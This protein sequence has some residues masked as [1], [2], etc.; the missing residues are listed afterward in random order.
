MIALHQNVTNCQNTLTVLTFRWRIFPQ[1]IRIG[2]I[3]MTDAGTTQDNFILLALPVGGL[4][5][6]QDRLDR[7]KL[8]RD[9][10]IPVTFP[11]GKNM[12]VNM[13][14]K[15][16][17]GYTNFDTRQIQG[18]LGTES[19]FSLPLMPIG[20]GTQHKNIMSLLIK[21][22]KHIFVSPS[23][24]R[25]VPGSYTVKPGDTKVSL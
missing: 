4:P 25:D 19:A 12:L 5:I 17:V 23:Q 22:K 11:S 8:V 20:L 3:C 24:S 7:M 16:S 13:L 6:S 21:F 9:R 1:N 14:F 18:R 15:I 2:Q 10:T